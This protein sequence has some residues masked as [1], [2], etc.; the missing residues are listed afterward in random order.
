[1]R[2]VSKA[3]KAQRHCKHLYLIL[4]YAESLCKYVNKKVFS[5]STRSRKA[6]PTRRGYVFPK[7]V[8]VRNPSGRTVGSSKYLVHQ[9]SLTTATTCSVERE[10][11]SH[12][13]DHFQHQRRFAHSV[14]LVKFIVFI[15]LLNKS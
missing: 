11:E 5:S 13:A 1:M 9:K 15:Q 3:W 14:F 2:H 8:L 6:R 4:F 10:G 7:C 12:R